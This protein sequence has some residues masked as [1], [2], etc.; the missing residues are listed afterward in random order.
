MKATECYVA[1]NAFQPSNLISIIRRR[2][3][4]RGRLSRMRL[5]IISSSR[6]L[7]GIA[8][9]FKGLLQV[10]RSANNAIAFTNCGFHVTKLSAEHAAAERF[11]PF[12]G[13][14]A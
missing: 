1:S 6:S 12:S 5:F 4:V 2:K 14:R 8:T 10:S 3:R 11:R 9:T 7:T 13:V